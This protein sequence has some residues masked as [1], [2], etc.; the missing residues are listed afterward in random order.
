MNGEWQGVEGTNFF[1]L[2]EY[3]ASKRLNAFFKFSRVKLV[4]WLLF[5]NVA[6][7]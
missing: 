4:T 6:F 1:E 7:S 2:K 3:L 5:C